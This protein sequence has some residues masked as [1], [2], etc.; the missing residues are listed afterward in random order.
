MLLLPSCIDSYYG[1]SDINSVN[2]REKENENIN[3]SVEMQAYG[4]RSEFKLLRC[5]VYNNSSVQYIE[6]VLT[7]QFIIQ[8]K[9][10]KKKFQLNSVLAPKGEKEKL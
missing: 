7:L 6:F 5:E 4:E 10:R 2:Q 1:R 9:V 8:E 3:L